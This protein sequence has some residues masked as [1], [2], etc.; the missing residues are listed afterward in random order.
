MLC[1]ALREQFSITNGKHGDGDCDATRGRHDALSTKSPVALGGPAGCIL[2]ARYPVPLS[3]LSSCFLTFSSRPQQQL[4]QDK[5]R[6]FSIQGRPVANGE[7]NGA[8][9][10]LS[11][12]PALPALHAVLHAGGGAGGAAGGASGPSGAP[13]C[14]AP[15][16]TATPGPGGPGGHAGGPGPR[17]PR[18]GRLVRRSN[19]SVGAPGTP[20]PGPGGGGGIGA[21]TAAAAAEVADDG[22]LQAMHDGRLQVARTIREKEKNPDRISLDR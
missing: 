21:A 2:Q 17:A 20:L 3:I 13:P 12:A 5:K 18:A 6:A 4:Q 1:V 10:F 9:G 22:E 16:P 7:A 14:P 19:S 15:G 8:R 11:V